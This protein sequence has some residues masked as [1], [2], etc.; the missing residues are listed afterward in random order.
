MI[1]EDERTVSTLAAVRK[2]GP[3]TKSSAKE[4]RLKR[5]SESSA[6]VTPKRLS[7]NPKSS[8]TPAKKRLN[9]SAD[10]DVSP[11]GIGTAE[12]PWKCS[13]LLFSNSSMP[14]KPSIL[15]FFRQHGLEEV[16]TVTPKGNW[17]ILVV[18]EGDIKKTPK[19]LMSLVLQKIIT[20]DK[21]MVHSAQKGKITD[22]ALFEPPDLDIRRDRRKLFKGRHIFVTRALK[23]EYGTGFKDI[24]A[25]VKLAGAE[26][27]VSKV[28]R[29]SDDI[30]KG[31]GKDVV[32]LALERDDLESISLMDHGVT[33]YTKDLLSTSILR[34]ELE[35]GDDEFRIAPLPSQSKRAK[36]GKRS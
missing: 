20:S 7:S 24:Q 8:A 27:V 19:L 25:V 1:D 2:P 14:S 17:D 28:L 4:S 11:E 12:D 26:S 22:P 35:L 5:N 21:W 29:S 34:G 30:T 33:C 6:H 36:G 23:K 9:D 13:K 31:I 3:G 32:V 10:S 15:K 18:G 16:K